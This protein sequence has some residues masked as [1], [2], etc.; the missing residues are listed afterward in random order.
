MKKSFKIKKSVVESMV[1]EA[2]RS[3][4]R[5]EVD[6]GPYDA[7]SEKKEKAQ[8]RKSE[9]VADN[10]TVRKLKKEIRSLRQK[11]EHATEEEAAEITRQIQSLKN[12][13]GYMKIDESFKSQK[14]KDFAKQ[15]GGLRYGDW[16]RSFENDLYNMSDED[17]DTYKVVD[18]DEHYK[19]YGIN[20]TD[21]TGYTNNNF[22]PIEFGDGTFMVKKNP[23]FGWDDRSDAVRFKAY[24]RW[25]EKKNDGKNEYQFENPY[26]HKKFNDTDSMGIKPRGKWG[27]PGEGDLTSDNIN[28]K[29]LRQM[30]IR[31]EK[32][33][34]ADSVKPGTVADRTRAS[35]KQNVNEGAYGYPDT[36]DGI[37]LC[38][39]NDREL[40][41]MYTGIA[42]ACA[43]LYK[44]NTQLSL[45]RLM[46]SSV[47]KKYQQA[48]FRKYA[49]EQEDLD[50]MKSPSLFRRFIADRIIE[51]VV[52]GVWDE[53]P[54]NE[55][56]LRDI[57]I[58][59]SWDEF[60][61]EH[62]YYPSVGLVSAGTGKNYVP[63]DVD[64]ALGYNNG[65]KY[66]TAQE[67]QNRN[68]L[69]SKYV[70]GERTPDDIDDAWYGIH[71][72][73]EEPKQYGYQNVDDKFVEKCGENGYEVWVPDYCLPYLVNGDMDI[74]D[75]DEIAEMQAFEK[76]F[77]GKLLKGMNAGDF[78]IPKDGE[79][80]S[81]VGKNDVFPKDMG[82]ECYKFFLPAK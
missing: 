18:S 3:M 45:E 8:Q 33:I 36:I 58:R 74:Y 5:E 49:N 6:C 65:K 63:D 7:A 73:I 75:E 25:K 50:R 68:K 57:E 51:E 10:E 52:S 29:A 55:E 56:D 69:M 28:M 53:R 77:E 48:C 42:K 70:S 71:E 23:Q 78:C 39:D 66:W 1:D 40:H 11:V 76:R 26:L 67:L 19:K 31:D 30:A 47:M 60:D 35:R 82:A 12:R 2:I 64:T 17:F 13:L 72:D 21:T 81:L 24:D 9:D 80:P 20:G 4:L 14:L 16:S 22:Q 43:K 37:V 44:K 79:S 38:S 34:T 41:E 32:G 54:M 59:D 61:N 46:D 15:H 27:I 62:N